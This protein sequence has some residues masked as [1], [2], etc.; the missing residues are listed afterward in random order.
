MISY[1]SSSRM[2]TAVRVAAGLAVCVLVGSVQSQAV[3]QT[4]DT[5]DCVIREN[6]VENAYIIS[7]Q[8]RI[9]PGPSSGD[10]AIARDKLF[11]AQGK[12]I[13]TT[14]AKTTLYML[15]DDVWQMVEGHD[16]FTDGTV[17][18]LGPSSISAALSGEMIMISATGMSGRYR[19]KIGVRTYQLVSREA[20]HN[21]YSSNLYVCATTEE[22]TAKAAASRPGK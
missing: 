19:N 7:R 4:D 10:V 12:R 3:A 11:D 20:D 8:D 5:E 15:N 14:D 21:V 18:L 16:R 6:F 1:R 2:R 13:G 22:A 17:Y 9:I